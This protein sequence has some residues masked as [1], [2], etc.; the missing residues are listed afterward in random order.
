[1]GA[2]VARSR[3]HPRIRGEHPAVLAQHSCGLG[4]SPHTRGAR[5]AGSRRS[6]RV[7]IIPA[8]AGS[9]G[10]SQEV[11][12]PAEDHPRIRGEHGSADPRQDSEGGSSPHTRGA[13]FL[14]ASLRRIPGIIPAYAGSTR[15][16][17]STFHS[18]ADHPRI[19]GE[20]CPASRKRPRSTGSSPHTRGA[21]AG[22]VTEYKAGG[23]IPA[24]AG[25]TPAGAG[26][27]G[28]SEG[29]SPHTRGARLWLVQYSSTRRIIPAYA[30]STGAGRRCA[31]LRGDHPRIRGEHWPPPPVC[32]PPWIIPAYAGS[33]CPGRSS[34]ADMAGSSP[35]T[36]GARK[37]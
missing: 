2:K 24:Y 5:R 15:L 27:S 11:A 30:G 19:R 31:G 8:Y 10:R 14:S 36:R 3:D 20:H 16:I 13:R 21:H 22:G 35:H 34:R 33:T 9:T 37:L 28:L 7:R 23:I 6:G 18:S 25:S 1:M 4:S 26:A 12:R 17:I 29:S 32:G